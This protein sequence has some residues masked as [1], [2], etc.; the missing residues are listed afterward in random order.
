MIAER[1]AEAQALAHKLG[2]FGIEN[3][4]TRKLLRTGTSVA[5]TLDPDLLRDV[6]GSAKPGQ[7]VKVGK[8][9]NKIVIT[10]A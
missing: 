8:E 2:L 10:S 3:A 7:M 1:V 4:Q 5:V 9:G 6:L